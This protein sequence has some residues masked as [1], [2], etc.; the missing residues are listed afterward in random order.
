LNWFRSSAACFE[1]IEK[2]TIPSKVS[3]IVFTDD[4]AHKAINHL[5]SSTGSIFAKEA[6]CDTIIPSTTGICKHALPKSP[7]YHA[8]PE[9]QQAILHDFLLHIDQGTFGIPFGDK[10]YC[11]SAGMDPVS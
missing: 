10:I 6:E 4:T 7:A 3:P 9:K 5:K 11:S 8:V 1:G 2:V